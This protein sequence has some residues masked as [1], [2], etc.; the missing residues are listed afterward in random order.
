[1]STPQKLETPESAV[2]AYVLI[3]SGVVAALQ[4]GKLPPALPEISQAL[5]M[6][7][8]QS[9]FLL[10]FIQ[11]AGMSLALAVGMSAD[12]FGAKRSMLLGLLM[13]GLA[14]AMG[15]TANSVAGLMVWRIFEGLGFLCV[16]LPAPG[17]IRQQVNAAQLRKLLGYWGAYMPA[18]TALTLLLG[19]LWLPEWGWRSWWMLFAVLSWGMALVLWRVVPADAPAFSEAIH[20]QQRLRETLSAPG[21]W[22]VT[23]CFGMYSGQWLAVVGFLPSIYTQAGLSGGTLGVLTAFAAAVNMLGNVMS[24]RL[25]QRGV[26][27]SVLL[28]MGFTAMALGAF[29]AFSELTLAMPW[30]RYAGVLLF[31]SCGG[32]VPGTLFYLAVRLAPQERNVSTTVGWMQQGSAAGQFA[33]PPLV[34][35]L[36]TWAGGWQWTW[37]AT[38]VCC[39]FGCVSAMMIARTLKKQSK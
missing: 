24:G 17:L 36:A 10:S 37:M 39:I 15:S 29:W 20:W 35:F 23:L 5:G 27:P 7:L 9:G 38:S 1:M 14:S 13:L 30:L 33:G 31:S 26:H 6:T 18:G 8:T 25:L 2:A 28:V 11:L 12:T 19:P 21:P 3:F 22:W 4:I 34:A 32:L 16:V